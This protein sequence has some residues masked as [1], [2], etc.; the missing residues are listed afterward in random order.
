MNSSKSDFRGRTLEVR[1]DV[2]TRAPERFLLQGLK[3]CQL[4]PQFLKIDL[5]YA[6]RGLTNVKSPGSPAVF[7]LINCV[8]RPAFKRFGTA[9][10]KLAIHIH[11]RLASL[12]DSQVR[13]VVVAMK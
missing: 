13:A 4:V 9:A 6:L 10:I 5:L 3:L 1:Y 7:V 8:A 12:A 11:K 2:T